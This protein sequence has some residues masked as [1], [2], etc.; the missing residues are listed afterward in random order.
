MEVKIQAEV[1]WVVKSCGFVVGYK[2]FRTSETFVS[3][4][5]TTRLHEPENLHLKLK[6]VR[7]SVHKNNTY[8]YQHNWLTSCLIATLVV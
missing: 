7:M 1:V 8:W 3:Y 2:R 5:K 4:H 6:F